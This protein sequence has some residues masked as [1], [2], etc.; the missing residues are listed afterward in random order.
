MSERGSVGVLLRQG[1]TFGLVGSSGVVVGSA[2]LN[3]CMAIRGNF[4]LAN[5][6]AFAVAVTWNCV[7]NRRFTFRSTVSGWPQQWLALQPSGVRGCPVRFSVQF[8][9]LAS[10]C[11]PLNCERRL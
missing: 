3:A 10:I 8:C 6:A 4:S 11:I 1:S 7:L 2:V 5:V 9:I